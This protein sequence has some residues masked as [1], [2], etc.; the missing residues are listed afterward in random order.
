VTSR[1][2]DLLTLARFAFAGCWRSAR[3]L[4]VAYL[5]VPLVQALLPAALVLTIRGL[6]DDLVR[7][8]HQGSFYRLH[9]REA[10]EAQPGADRR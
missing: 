8:Q 4:T 2:R 3:A 5:G 1:A 10:N 7:L 6:V 9:R